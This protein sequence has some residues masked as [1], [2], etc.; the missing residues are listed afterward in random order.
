[1]GCKKPKGGGS[2]PRPKEGGKP[3]PARTGKRK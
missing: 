3:T 1:M 2:K